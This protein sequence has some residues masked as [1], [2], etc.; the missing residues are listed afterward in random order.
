MRPQGQ[1]R[2]LL[3]S[4]RLQFQYQRTFDAR[5]SNLI[6]FDYPMRLEASSRETYF[7]R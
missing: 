2:G 6:R 5:A 3:T 4:F 1:D 7:L